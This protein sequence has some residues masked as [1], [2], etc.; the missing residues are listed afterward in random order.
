MNTPTHLPLKIQINRTA[1]EELSACEYGRYE[2]EGH[3]DYDHA[4]PHLETFIHRWRT[5]IEIRTQAELDEVFFSVCSG[6]FGMY[7]PRIALR[8]ADTLYPHTT[9]ALH[10]WYP[11]QTPAALG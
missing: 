5:Q 2:D 6:T 3:P 9:P 11:P 8:I 7:H 4:R 1:L 10:A